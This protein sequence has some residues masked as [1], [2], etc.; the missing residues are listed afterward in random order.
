MAVNLSPV[1]GVAQQFFT[2]NGVPLSGGLI[3]TY[4]AGSTT[5]AATYT[6]STGTIAHT[7][8]IVLDSSGRVPGGEIWLT[9]GITYKFVLK[10]SSSVLIGTYDNVNSINDPTALL[11]YEASI[12][13]SSGSS[14]VGYLASGTGAVATTVQA[15]LR[16]SVSVKDFGATGDGTTNDTAA[17]QAALNASAAV[18]FP[19]GTYLISSALTIPSTSAGSYL[20]GD[21][22][23][24][25]IIL[26]NTAV[27]PA[28]IT[29]ASGVTSCNLTDIQL[30]N[31]GGT[32]CVNV[33][34][35]TT[36]LLG[37]S[38]RV[39]FKG[40][41]C[42]SGTGPGTNP[43]MYFDKCAFFA[44]LATSKCISLSGSN[45]YN[46]FTVQNSVFF[47][48]SGAYGIDI[49][50]TNGSSGAL[51]QGIKIL[52]NTFEQCD[53]GA[54]RLGSSWLAYIVGNYFDDMTTPTQPVINCFKS[55]GSDY[56]PTQVTISGNYATSTTGVSF[57]GGSN[58]IISAN[59]FVIIDLNGSSNVQCINNNGACSYTNNNFRNTIFGPNSDANTFSY[60]S[61]IV[62]N[63][64]SDFPGSYGL[65]FVQS[66]SAI[67]NPFVNFQNYSGNQIG[68]ISTNS[69]TVAYNTSS[70]RRLKSNIVSI[71]TDQ[72]GPI[73]D[74]LKPRS[75]IWNTDGS[76]DIGFIA[77]E[78]QEV[79]PKAVTGT[80]NATV[81]I[82][83][84][85]DSTGKV[86]R[87]NV[88]EPTVLPEGQTWSITETKPIYQMLD[89]SQPE[90]IA[91][92]VAEVQS[93][94]AR[95]KAANIN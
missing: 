36:G 65:S 49:E 23:N 37:F 70:D 32:A 20:Y 46:D 95:L 3:Y 6:S 78:I 79:I 50:N 11:N 73:I 56:V 17:I 19:K 16:E 55:T 53:G 25:S 84:I 45:A 83:D 22:E 47:C 86:L 57:V 13:S 2:N 91:Y 74:A 85:T 81:S 82:G 42:I 44:D 63:L 35:A 52:N 66:S 69:S 48:K 93:L 27:S 90:M 10:D 80:P 40:N 33:T 1:G 71:T 9:N 54:I 7:N 38:Q 41:P 64:S 5:P 18:Y 68:S 77:D 34:D 60:G 51:I 21:G 12:A 89:V 4:V 75:F 14:L 76:A 59:R 72:S 94:R 87:T 92:L 67:T 43:V 39:I 8:P 26:T 58:S 61:Q 28:M 31:T 29:S 62:C 88:A 24:I 15:K 30:V